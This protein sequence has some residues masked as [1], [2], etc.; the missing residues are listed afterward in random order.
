MSKSTNK[1]CRFYT[2]EIEFENTLNDAEFRLFCLLQRIIDWDSKH[3]KTFGSVNITVRDIRSDYLNTWSTGKISENLNSLIEKGWLE[4]RGRSR[5]FIKDYWVYRVKDVR[6]VEQLVRHIRQGVQLPE[7][8]GRLVEQ[9]RQKDANS[10]SFK[11]KDLKEKLKE[12]VRLAEQAS[13]LKTL[14]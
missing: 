11:I 5:I 13:P 7:H 9:Y 10:A 12:N 8:L 3:E 14:K 2:F 4:R 1:F 6:F